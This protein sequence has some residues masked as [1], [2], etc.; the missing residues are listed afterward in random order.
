MPDLTSLSDEQLNK[1]CGLL[2]V[3]D[4]NPSPWEHP[5]DNAGVQW[6][7]AVKVRPNE[8]RSW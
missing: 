1:M 7:K 2:A 4:T 5:R 6:S 3:L 8:A